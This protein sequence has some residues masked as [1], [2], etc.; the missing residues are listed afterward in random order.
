M[1]KNP[2]LTPFWSSCFLTRKTDEPSILNPS[3]SVNL[4]LSVLHINVRSIKKNY[5]KLEALIYSLESPPSILCLSETWLQNEDDPRCFLIEGF[6][7]FSCRM[8]DSRGGGIIIQ[9][10]QD[11]SLIKEIEQDLAESMLAHLKK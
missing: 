3:T 11:V 5:N 4:S 6:T 7:H 2:I 1:P 10:R 9:I 8:R